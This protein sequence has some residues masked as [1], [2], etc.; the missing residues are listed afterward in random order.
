MKFTLLILSMLFV[1]GCANIGRSGPDPLQ[2]YSGS[3]V[4]DSY[5]ARDITY[6]STRSQAVNNSLI[7]VNPVTGIGTVIT[8]RGTTVISRQ[9]STTVILG[10]SSRR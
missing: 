9:G 3:T 7:N 6:T 2:F 10:G 4:P 1:T 8:D 5:G